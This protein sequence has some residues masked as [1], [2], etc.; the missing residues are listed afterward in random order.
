M[1]ATIPQFELSACTDA[2]NLIGEHGIDSARV[3]AEAA[4]RIKREQE[5]RIWREKMQRKLSECP[6]F[7]G[8]EPPSRELAGSVTV[9][10]A[11]LDEA[12]DFLT[13]RCH[14]GQVAW[15][16][17]LGLVVEVLPWRKGLTKAV[18]RRKLARVEQ[19]QLKFE[20]STNC[21]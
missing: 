13:R 14:V 5:A 7:V 1:K 2:F 16:K 19:F 10:P 21:I 12:M 20:A 4:E 18:A 8:C 15:R 11:A 6:G 3:A 9:Q 17:G